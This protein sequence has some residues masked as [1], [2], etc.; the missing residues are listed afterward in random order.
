MSDGLPISVTVGIFILA[1]IS[2]GLLVWRE[3]RPRVIGE[4]RMIPTTP[5]LFIAVVTALITLV[6][7]ATVLHGGPLKRGY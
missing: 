3:K 7:I 4:V 1:L 6:H 5:L 2:I